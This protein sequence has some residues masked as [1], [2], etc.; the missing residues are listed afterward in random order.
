MDSAPQ[1]AA[2]MVFL[3]EDSPAIRARLAATIKGIEG[4]ELV[5]EAGTVG[6][7]IDGI[8]STNPGA[9]ILDLQLDDGS[10]LEV[11][12]AVQPYAPVLHVAVLTNYATDQ[13]RR[14]CM[15]A[16]A[17]FFLDKSSDFARIR[18]IVQTWAARPEG[19]APG[20]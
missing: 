3:V 18:E 15:D 12:K 11:L 1:K 9:V 6:G 13:H 10:G 5:G 7:A 8:R 19:A 16:G 17:E 2:L 14:A 4:A 20:R